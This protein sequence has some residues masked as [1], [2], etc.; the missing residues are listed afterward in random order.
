VVQLYEQGKH[1][2][3]ELLSGDILLVMQAKYLLF[4]MAVMM[5]ASISVMPIGITIKVYA[6]NATTAN[7]WLGQMTNTTNTTRVASS[8]GE[9]ECAGGEE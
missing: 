2:F 1:S 4:I 6:Q 5:L 3:G 9:N 7:T 8:T